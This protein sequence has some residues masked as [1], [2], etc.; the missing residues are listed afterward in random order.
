MTIWR[1]I[2]NWAKSWSLPSLPDS[3]LV[4]G[5]IYV[6][7][8]CAIGIDLKNGDGIAAGIKKAIGFS[9]RRAERTGLFFEASLFQLSNGQAQIID[10]E[11]RLATGG[12]SVIRYQQKR[13]GADFERRH[14]G[15]ETIKIPDFL[16]M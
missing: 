4:L 2:S 9:I 7:A 8:V 1:R 12:F 6:A 15:T 16:C 10:F 13:T 14:L 5:R 11:N 3:I